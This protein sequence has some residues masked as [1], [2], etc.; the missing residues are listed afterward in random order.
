MATEREV[1]REKNRKWFFNPNCWC[2]EFYI[3]GVTV[4]MLLGV[5]VGLC[6]ESAMYG[7]AVGSVLPV[8]TAAIGALAGAAGATLYNLKECLSRRR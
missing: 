7:N 1:R 6:I 8:M 2:G 4:G 5:A 3:P